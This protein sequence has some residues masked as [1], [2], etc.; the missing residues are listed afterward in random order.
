MKVAI[1]H[2][3]LVAWRGGERVLRAIAD[4]YPGADIYSHVI[5]PDL[6][7]EHF[8]EHVVKPTFIGR[9]PFSRTLYQSYLPLMPL[10]LEQLDL[11]S[12]DLVISSESGPA[13]GVIT[14]PDSLHVCYCHSPMRYLWDMYHDYMEGSGL[15]KRGLRTPLLHYMRLWDQAS[16]DRVDHFAANSRFVARRIHK[17]YRRGATVVHPPVSVESFSINSTTG[18][19][20]LYVGQLVK[21]K[22]PDLVVE[23]FNQS[24]RPLVMIG[25][26]EMFATIAAKAHPNIRILGR[27]PLDVI[28]SHYS[29][30]RAL[31]FP[32]LEDFGIVPV[33][34]MASGRPVIA[35]GRGGAVETI[36]DRKTGILFEE[37]SVTALN[38]A[39]SLFES[40]EQ[41]FDAEAI[42][43]HAR[44]FSEERFKNSFSNFMSSIMDS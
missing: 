17:Y 18:D 6:A 10:A 27:Q 42:R 33:E 14:H 5:D 30:C 29:T 39:V 20:Y 37:Q 22:R 19:F 26:G 8:P 40:L 13:K 38:R 25:E 32:G 44:G 4:I 7:S 11:R 24:G 36:I 15:I 28:R 23:A 1:V 21:Y 2:Y 12:Y 31:V 16:A 43:A 9:L 41:S 35:Y 34:A 3:W